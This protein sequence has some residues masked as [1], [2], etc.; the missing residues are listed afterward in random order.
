MFER[1]GEIQL[2]EI[3]ALWQHLNPDQPL[4]VLGDFN[5]FATSPAV[6]FLRDRGLSDAAAARRDREARLCTWSPPGL[7]GLVC[8]RIDHVLHSRYFLSDS[9]RVVPSQAS[10]HRPLVV[11]LRLNPN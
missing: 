1:S 8:L 9:L 2:P 7:D 10:D 5:G 6:G 4:V 11:A 3:T